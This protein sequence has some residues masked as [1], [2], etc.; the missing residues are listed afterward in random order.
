MQRLHVVIGGYGRVGRYLARM[1]EF[2]GHTVSVIDKDPLEF[3]S[4]DAEEI[5]GQKFVGAVFDRD[6]LEDA[7]SRGALQVCPAVYA[8][9]LAFPGREPR[10]VDDFLSTSGISI[11]WEITPATWR[12]AGIAF[13]AYSTRRDASGAGPPS[14]LLVDFL[15]GAHALDVGTLITRDLGFYGT[16]FPDLRVISPVK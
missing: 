8:E 7:I 1:L 4:E 5:M 13:A 15:V 11:A 16:N 6:V 3:E 14:R 9:L 12:R 10:D 2:E